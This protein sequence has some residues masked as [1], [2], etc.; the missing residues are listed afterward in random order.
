MGK[1]K[2]KI[3][4][5]G[6]MGMLKYKNDAGDKIE[7]AYDQPYSKELGIADGTTVTF[8]LINKA[9]GTPM[10]VAVNPIEKGNI[11]SI[12]IKA[13]TGVIEETESS[14]KY[15]FQQNYLLE[16]KLGIG[17]TVK[18]TL[19]SADGIITAVCLTAV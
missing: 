12:D 1:L 4:R 10:A 19:V 9:D 16:S 13:G 14:I 8:D 7:V 5:P 2:G 11:I 6:T 3:T 15:P 17:Q 18:Y